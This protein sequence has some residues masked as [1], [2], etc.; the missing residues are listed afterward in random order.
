MF[1]HIKFCLLWNSD[2]RCDHAPA[3][4]A[5]TSYGLKNKINY[6][7]AIKKYCLLW[8]RDERGD[9]APSSEARTSCDQENYIK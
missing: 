2:E 5:R 3:S 6:F 8:V 7:L 9:H 4:E 1:R